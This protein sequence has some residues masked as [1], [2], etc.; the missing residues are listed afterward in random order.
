[1]KYQDILVNLSFDWCSS[2]NEI[3]STEWETI[4][5]KNVIKSQRF[6]IA[7]EKSGFS[8]VSYYYLRIKRNGITIS[9]VPCFN[10]KIDILNITTSP[11]AKYIIQSI[12][13]VHSNFLC[14]KAFVTGSYATSCEHFIEYRFDL[15]DEYRKAVS[16]VINQQLKNKC[17]ET[18]SKFI[19]IKDVRGR[20]LTNVQ[21]LI[22]PDFHFFSSFP[23]T[24]IPILPL[25]TYPIALKSKYR[26]RFYDN[27]KAFDQNFTWEIS[28][29]YASHVAQFASLYEKVLYKAE[30]K[31]EFLNLDFFKHINALYPNDSF[32]LMAKNKDDE[33]RII[34]LV[35]ENKDCLIPL[36]MGINYLND[37]TRVLYINALG[38][39]VQ[40]A[41][42]RRKS[43]VDLGQTSYY[44]KVMSGA[45]A[46]DIH[47]GFWSNHYLLKWLI[48]NV[49][50]KIFIPLHIPEN[51][52]LEKYRSIAYDILENR[53]FY[54]LNK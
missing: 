37:D 36:Y 33:I 51:V 54:L 12:R 42:N 32:L 40:E 18:K 27:K 8:D 26:K 4:F 17:K 20:D 48:K 28:T 11:I 23:T 44:P 38:R 45:F 34:I 50:H 7:M 3:S 31:F 19:F 6:F 13:K 43:Y 29:N 16:E 14:I 47:Y 1:M 21:K 46:E 30:N 39:I 49:F 53:G 35:L 22:D 25:H 41:E 2:V 10:Y 9:I 5:G 24:V 15:S 52:Y